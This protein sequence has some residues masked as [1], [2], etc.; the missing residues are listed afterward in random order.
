MLN[1]FGQFFIKL[2]MNDD[3]R[4]LRNIATVHTKSSGY[5]Y[6]FAAGMDKGLFDEC[7]VFGR[8]L[9]QIDLVGV[10]DVGGKCPCRQFSHA[11]L[12]SINLGG[13]LGG[14][15]MGKR[16]SFQSYSTWRK[17]PIGFDKFL[18]VFI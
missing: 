16:G 13:Q 12:P 5:V 3:L 15:H 4:F 8:A 18:N 1:D 11:T 14:G 7:S 2:T 17:L 6:D 10:V 9:F